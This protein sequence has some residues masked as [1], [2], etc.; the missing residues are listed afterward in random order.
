M[1]QHYSHLSIYE[2]RLAVRLYHYQ[3]KSI[4]EIGRILERPHTTI[5]REIKRHQ[6]TSYV[7]TYYPNLAETEYA[8]TIRDRGQRMRLKNNTTKEY[9]KEKLK[10]GWSPEIISGRLKIEEDLSYVC[11]ESIYQYIYKE[12]PELT[13]YL[14]RKHKKRRKKHPYRSTPG[15]LQ[16]RTSIEERPTAAN[17]RTEHGHWESDSI[18]SVGHKPGCNVLVERLTRLTHITKVATQNSDDT[19][20]AII[21]SLSHYPSDFTRSI[22][23]DNGSENAQH[24]HTNTQLNCQSYF[25]APYHSWEKGSVEQVNGLV[26]RYLPKSSDLTVVPQKEYDRIE[27]L[28]NSR[29]RKCLQ[30]KTPYEAYEAFTHSASP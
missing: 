9:I 29:P 26:R 11:H 24:V 15:K 28:L 21:Q 6:F 18:V 4:R 27:H 12:A 22:T 13:I 19:S 1:G 14:P 3:K 30:F 16:N 20:Q 2:R 7:S 23:Y 17:E 10:I 25:C 5:S 8:I